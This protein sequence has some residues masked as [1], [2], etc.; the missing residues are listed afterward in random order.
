MSEHHLAPHLPAPVYMRR[1][2]GSFCGA[3]RRSRTDR[4]LISRS[5]WIDEHQTIHTLWRWMLW[6]KYLIVF[7]GY[8]VQT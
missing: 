5:A 3:N 8:T 2:G 4:P 1:S 7:D 6:N